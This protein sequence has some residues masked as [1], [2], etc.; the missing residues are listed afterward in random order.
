VSDQI[1][2]SPQNDAYRAGWERIWGERED[3]PRCRTCQRLLDENGK[4]PAQEKIEKQA[5]ALRSM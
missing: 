2:T 5:R 4:C 1:I 3:A